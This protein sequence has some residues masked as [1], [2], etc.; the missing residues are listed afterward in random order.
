MKE[1]VTV[2]ETERTAELVIEK[3]RF[4]AS[5]IHTESVEEAAEYIAAKKKKYFDAT[6]NCYA[7]ICGGRAKF[8]DDGEPQG[9]A[10]IPIYECIKNNGLDF[11]CVVVTRYF[12]GV[13]LGAGGLVRAYTASAADALRLCE[14]VYMTDCVD[15]EITVDYSLLGAVRKSLE[16]EAA[17]ITADFAD[18]VK[19]VYRFPGELYDTITNIV[20]ESTFGKA[21][22]K[23][24]DRCLRPFRR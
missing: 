21:E 16:N 1:Y 10:G 13:K 4:I 6:H 2:S 5:C 7:Y 18:K 9:T 14:K 12:G 19:L 23:V 22:I 20:I 17:E 24:K 8:S 3:S 15:A 11:V